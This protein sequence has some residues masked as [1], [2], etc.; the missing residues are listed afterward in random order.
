VRDSRIFFVHYRTDKTTAVFYKRGMNTIPDPFDALTVPADLN[1][2][3]WGDAEGK[4]EFSRQLGRALIDDEPSFQ[5]T[6][7]LDDL[8]RPGTKTS[9]A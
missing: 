1:A 4:S 5:D 7:P 2:I 8:P 6:V 9:A 3:P